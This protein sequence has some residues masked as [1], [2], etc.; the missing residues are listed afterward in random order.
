MKKESKCFDCYPN[1]EYTT[2]Q[3]CAFHWSMHRGAWYFA[4]YIVKGLWCKAKRLF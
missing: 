2:Y 4:R 1:K 3:L